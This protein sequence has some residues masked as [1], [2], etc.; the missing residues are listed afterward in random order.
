MIRR[1]QEGGERMSQV[2][3]DK[4]IIATLWGRFYDRV[5][6]RLE[7]PVRSF[8][9]TWTRAIVF[10]VLLVNLLLM[11]AAVMP[12]FWLYF[13]DQKLKWNGA[14]PNGQ[15]LLLLRDAVAAALFTGPV[16]TVLVI[17]AAM[18]NWRKRLRGGSGDT[19]PTGGYR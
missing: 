11:T 1:A 12:S 3:S 19:R 5:L 16:V 17:G 18:Q 7:G 8:E 13:A 15:I 6:R 9:W 14:G 10:S 2:A 4:G